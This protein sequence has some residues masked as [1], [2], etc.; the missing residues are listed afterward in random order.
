MR[1]TKYAPENML[2]V[3][4]IKKVCFLMWSFGKHLQL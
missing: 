1:K 2:I 3:S 4:V